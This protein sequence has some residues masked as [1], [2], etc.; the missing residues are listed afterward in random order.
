LYTRV[1]PAARLPAA[2][3]A[4][5]NPA[6]SEIA[7]AVLIHARRELESLNL[8]FPILTLTLVAR[9]RRTFWRASFALG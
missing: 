5:A 3:C 9:A 8:M 2:D 6:D 1:P 4:L 7:D